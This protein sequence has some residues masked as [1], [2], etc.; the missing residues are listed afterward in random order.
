MCLW[1]WTKILAPNEQANYGRTNRSICALVDLPAG[2]E[3]TK[4]NTALLRVEKELRPGLHPR[5]YAF[6]LGRK[7]VAEVKAGDGI[8]WGE[9]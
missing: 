7:L 5:H 2:T 6:I 8:T 1:G 4:E 9:L 3:L